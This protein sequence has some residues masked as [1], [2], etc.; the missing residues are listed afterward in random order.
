MAASF[1]VVTRA[2]AV[3]QCSVPAESRQDLLEAQVGQVSPVRLSPPRCGSSVSGGSDEGWPMLNSTAF[4]R[5][6]TMLVT[7]PGFE[8]RKK[9]T[10]TLYYGVRITSVASGALVHKLR[11]TCCG[12]AGSP[13][14]A[15]STGTS[16]MMSSK[17]EGRE[18]RSSEAAS[19]NKRRSCTG[20][21]RASRS[22]PKVRM[23]SMRSRPRSAA[24]RISSMCCG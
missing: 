7:E 15:A 6:M 21:T 16:S 17:F 9:G 23:L 22:R 19:S 8:K 4:G 11:T 5:L 20:R 24:R 10:I 13:D 12:C 2:D 18:A 3:T 14:T 1:S